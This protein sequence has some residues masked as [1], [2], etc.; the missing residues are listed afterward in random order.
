MRL[1]TAKPKTVAR[2][3]AL[4]RARTEMFLQRRAFIVWQMVQQEFQIPNK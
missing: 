2:K 3:L 4:Y 1:D